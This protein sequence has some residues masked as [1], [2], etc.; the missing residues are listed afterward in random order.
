M[1]GE[2]LRIGIWVCAHNEQD[3][4]EYCLRSVYDFANA[5]AVSVNTGVPWG[6]MAV[7]LDNTLDIVSSFPDPAGK[8]IIVSGQWGS[9]IEQREATF[10]ALRHKS[11]YIMIVD[12]DEVYTPGD[13]A[14][15]R[16][17]VALRPYI[18]QFR[19]RMRTYWSIRPFHVIS[20]PEPYRR[21]LI[22]RFKPRTKLI[23]IHRTN[24]L[25]RCMIPQSVAVC[26]HFSYARTDERILQKLANTLHRPEL[27][28]GWYENVWLKW[29]DNHDLEDLHPTH[30]C[31]FKRAIPVDLSALP[32]VMRDHP[33]AASSE[34]VVSTGG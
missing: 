2:R 23:G 10:E 25:W 32:E 19:I 11:D 26:H 13:L 34:N 33:Y 6:G 22:S 30:P 1:I 17:F 21:Y 3:Y 8:L 5:I 15:L 7:P 24:E 18:G 28:P 4:I 29:K 16:R 12:A 27:V 20:P 9:E 31:E 14:R